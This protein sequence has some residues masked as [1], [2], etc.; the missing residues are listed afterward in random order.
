MNAVEI[1]NLSKS[2]GR[3]QALNDLSFTVPEGALFGLIGPNGAGKTTA[4]SVLAG[5]LK[6][7]SGSVSVRGE[8]LLPGQPPRGRIAMLPQ[9]AELLPRMKALDVLRLLARYDGLS[10]DEARTKAQKVLKQV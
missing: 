3:I 5:Y 10:S 7:N 2:F 6:P 8:P 9:D 1:H 4:F